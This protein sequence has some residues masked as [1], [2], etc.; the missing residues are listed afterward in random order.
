MTYRLALEILGGVAALTTL[1]VALI[2]PTLLRE[3]SDLR[4]TI[5]RLESDKDKG[6]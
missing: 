3:M 6:G 4:N 5:G 1:L 2:D